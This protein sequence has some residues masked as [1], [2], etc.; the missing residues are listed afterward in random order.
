MPRIGL[1]SDSHGRASTTR[2]AVRLLIAQ[3]IDALLHL[4]D[5]G[6]LEVI[7]ELLVA[8]PVGNATAAA[9]ESSAA[10]GRTKGKPA[11]GS[12][13]VPTV[14]VYL[15]FGNVDWDHAS[16]A[17]YAEHLGM[18]VAHPLGRI[19]LPGG[20]TLAYT[21]GDSGR[22]MQQALD[23]QVAFLCHG[24]SHRTRDERIGPTRV[25]NPGALFRAKQYTAAVLDTDDDD[26]AFFT[27]SS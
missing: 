8:A 25:I 5:V 7:D 26:L 23:E 3:E 14:D 6:T 1:L 17:R 20:R 12:S 21:H 16:M 19:A 10:S 2:R 11:G 15:T 27:V 4:G 22:A 9:G 24:H 13:S 18:T